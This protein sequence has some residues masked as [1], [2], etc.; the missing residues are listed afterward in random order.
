[1]FSCSLLNMA[2]EVSC[3]EMGVDSILHWQ[4]VTNYTLRTVAPTSLKFLARR[5]RKIQWNMLLSFQADFCILTMC[6]YRL[7]TPTRWEGLLSAWMR[8]AGNVSSNQSLECLNLVIVQNWCLV[9]FCERLPYLSN[10]NGPVIVWLHANLHTYSVLVLY[11]LCRLL[12]YF[13]CIVL[14]NIT[15]CNKKA[16]YGECVAS[17]CA[18]G[19]DYE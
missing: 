2:V 3:S 5:Y 9:K 12:L 16:N 14:N 1:M 8:A 18:V 17:L 13:M 11:S 19:L 6:A 4:S 7:A 15:R 10:C